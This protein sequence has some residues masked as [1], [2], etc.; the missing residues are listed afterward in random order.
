MI[1]EKLKQM[2]ELIK[3]CPELFH[4][5]INHDLL[6]I[7]KDIKRLIAPKPIL[8]EEILNFEI[9][10]EYKFILR[11]HKFTITPTEDC[12]QI[13][14][15]SNTGRI[16][17]LNLKYTNDFIDNTVKEILEFVYDNTKDKYLKRVLYNEI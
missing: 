13:K 14:I 3:S 1:K 4:D 15:L 11:S 5:G 6:D 16:E 8:S 2:E 17:L 9:K 10:N 7:I 12:Y